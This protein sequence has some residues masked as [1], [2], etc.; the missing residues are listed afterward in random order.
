MGSALPPISSQPPI[1]STRNRA[2]LKDTESSP[3]RALPLLTTTL[4]VHAPY[5]SLTPPNNPL[6]VN[7]D[8]QVTVWNN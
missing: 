5:A 6:K 1:L 4:C 8:L 7:P 2:Y 3:S